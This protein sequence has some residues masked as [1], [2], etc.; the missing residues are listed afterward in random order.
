M[1]E[2]NEWSTTAA[3]NN[4]AA[5][6]GWPENMSYSDVNNCAR[7]MMAV[8]ARWYKDTNGTLTTGGSSTAYTLAANR[9]ISA[10]AAGMEFAFKAHT[11]SGSNP[12]L[13]V[14]GVGAVDMYEQN[15]SQVDSSDLTANR[16]YRAVY[17]STGPKFWVS[18]F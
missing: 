3:S 4:S 10:Y 18:P 13:N 9:T 1:A 5:P 8:L 17:D 12:T 2:I 7:E 6:D 15:G 16:I 14:D 11:T